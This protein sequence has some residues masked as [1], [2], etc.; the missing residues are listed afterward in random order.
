MKKK[1]QNSVWKLFFNDKA[2]IMLYFTMAIC[3][4][5][6]TNLWSKRAKKY[7]NFDIHIQQL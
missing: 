2:G 5:E 7:I 4:A 1:K 3:F 6:D